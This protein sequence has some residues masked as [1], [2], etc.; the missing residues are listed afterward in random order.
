MMSVT[1]TVF[2]LT[3][4]VGLLLWFGRS[5]EVSVHFVPSSFYTILVV[6]NL[7]PYANIWPSVLLGLLVGLIHIV[8]AVLVPGV[9]TYSNTTPLI[10]SDVI[11]LLVVNVFGILTKC[12]KEITMRRAFLDRRRCIETTIKLNYEKSQEVRL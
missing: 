7:L 4:D 5:D 1:M 2:L 6:Y 9:S 8:V 11:Y 12:L 10:V 3:V